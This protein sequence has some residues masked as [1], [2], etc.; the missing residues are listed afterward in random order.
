MRARIHLGATVVSMLAIAS[1]IA[2]E[3]ACV[4][5]PTNGQQPVLATHVQDWR[6]EV[7]YQLLVDRFAD[8]DINNDYAVQPGALARYQGGDW[9]GIEDH[10]DYLQTL[11]VTTL[12]IS[13]V[14][15][16][17]ETDADVD[18]YHGYWAQDLTQPN[19]HFGDLAALRSMVASAHDRG[20]KVVLDI[21]TN[22][23]GQVFFY[24]MNE[25][26]HPDVYISG[27][28]TPPPGETG[29]PTSPVTRISE[30]DPDWDSRGVQAFTSLGLSGRAPILFIHDPTINREPPQ[31]GILG[32]ID[33]YHGFGR[34]LDYSVDAQRLLGD[35]PG[36]LKDVNT[37]NPEV[38]ATMVDAYSRWVEQCD[39]DGF[40]IDTVKHVEHEFWQAFTQGVRTRLAAEGKNDFI[41]FGEAFDGNDQ[42]L[43]SYT[44][45]GELDSVFYFSQ[46]FQVF[47][48]IFQMAH[49]PTQQKGTDQIAT[50]WAQR[51]VNY[52]SD[53]QDNGIGIPPKKALVNFLDNHDVSRFLFDANGD[54]AALRN[55]LTLLFMEEGIPN[56]YYG[57]EQDLSGGNDPA[58]R[59]VLWLENFD[60]SGDTFNHI[61][62]LARIRKAYGA[63]RRGDTK[64]VF[65]TPHV[66]AEPDA[67]MFAFERAGGDAGGGYALVVVNTNAQKTGRIT[68]ATSATGSLVDVLN[69]G[70]AQVQVAGGGN[71]DVSVPAQSAV[72][73]VPSDQLQPGT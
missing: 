70:G 1:A 17:V 38:R 26:G 32:R 45:K 36:G 33:G 12:W 7:V 73:L 30:F 25:N 53:P 66:A 6:D 43:G 59:E 50:L 57:T 18:A 31:P 44:V 4:S 48:D 20:L 14:V 29:N 21:V 22:H 8:G 61:A 56:L 5:V 68:T 3:V 34:V 46:H 42:L 47:H 19:P 60:T 55:A 39:L 37:E 71:V 28:G 69:P 72:V 52:G 51:E 15:K 40:R 10:L 54:L 9:K 58:N 16:N 13:P 35:F 27:T 64:V 11:G 41:M 67:G 63:I 23:M 65:S 24:D 2:P 49:D 62:K